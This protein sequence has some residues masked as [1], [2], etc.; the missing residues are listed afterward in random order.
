MAIKVG[1]II[2]RYRGHFC[3][4]W[5]PVQVNRIGGERPNMI[6]LSLT[7]RQH[8]YALVRIRG[9]RFEFDRRTR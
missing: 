5:G 9:L 7:T 6:E 1:K 3:W 4:L 2:H 8:I